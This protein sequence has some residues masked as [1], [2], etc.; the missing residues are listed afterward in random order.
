VLI[1]REQAAEF[2]VTAAG[3]GENVLA[4]LGEAREALVTA[5][6]GGHWLVALAALAG[7]LM[8]HRLPALSIHGGAARRIGEVGENT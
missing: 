5:I 8:V 7:L 1:D 2:A 3:A 4:I 6:H